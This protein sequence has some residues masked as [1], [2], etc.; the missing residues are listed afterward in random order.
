[1]QGEP[2]GGRPQPLGLLPDRESAQLS[3]GVSGCE[4]RSSAISVCMAELNDNPA[5]GPSSAA[6]T[7][8]T[9]SMTASR[10]SAGS[11]SACPGCGSSSG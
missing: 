9:D 2:A 5:T 7:S 1:M 8:R 11:C 3:D 10:I 6:T 4:S